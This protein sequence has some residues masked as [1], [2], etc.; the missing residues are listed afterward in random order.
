MWAIFQNP[1]GFLTFKFNGLLQST[2]IRKSSLVGVL[3]V[4]AL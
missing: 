2:F 3:L 1:F 4:L